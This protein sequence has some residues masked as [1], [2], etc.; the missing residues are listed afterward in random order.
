MNR[1]MIMDSSTLR[2]NGIDIRIQRGS[3]RMIDRMIMNM[4]KMVVIMKRIIM[5]MVRMRMMNII[6]NSSQNH[7]SRMEVGI[8]KETAEVG[9][10]MMTKM[11]TDRT[12][13]RSKR[14]I[15]E[16]TQITNKRGIR[17]IITQEV[18]KDIKQM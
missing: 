17:D 3:Q 4:M 14:E 11:A 2:R 9:I 5:D 10:G 15:L 7:H 16:S 18:I 13:I 8:G 1:V 6:M 12:I